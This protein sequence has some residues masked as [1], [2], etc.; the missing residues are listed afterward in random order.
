MILTI[1]SIISQKGVNIEMIVT[2]DGSKNNY[3]GKLKE[4]LRNKGVINYKLIEHEK[5][6][7]TVLN[8]YGGVTKS[9]YK[10]VKVISP[11]D[12]LAED[13]VLYKWIQQMLHKEYEWSFSDAIYYCKDNGKYIAVERDT[14]PQM[15]KPY[16]QEDVVSCRWN[17]VVNDDIALGAAT[18]STLDILKEYLERIINKVKYAEDNVWRLMV[19]DGIVPYYHPF[20]TILYECNTGISTSGGDR[21]SKLLRADWDATNKIMFDHSN[22]KDNLQ[23]EMKK[24]IFKEYS[25]HKIVRIIQKIKIPGKLLLSIKRKVSPRLSS[26]KYEFKQ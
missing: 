5:N 12:I 15:V 6:Q 20:E 8:I 23:K 18:F 25:N 19:Y 3:F 10:F 4:Y 7:G 22:D 17:Y 24:Y 16:I 26:T 1:D 9:S 21:W 14:H 11:G 2:D 13:D